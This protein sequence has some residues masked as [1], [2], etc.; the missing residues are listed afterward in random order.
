M[1]QIIRLF[2]LLI[3]VIFL[4][5]SWSVFSEPV[6]VVD[7]TGRLVSLKAPANR[8]VTLAPS[9]VEITYAAGAG[10]KVVGTVEYSDYPAAALKIPRVGGYSRIDLEAIID[11]KPDL[12][13]GWESGNS[14]TAIE[15]LRQL[16]IPVYLSQPNKITDIADDI[17]RIGILAGTG[18]VANKTAHDFRKRYKSLAK[19]YEKRPPVRLFYQISPNPLITIGGQQVI[20]DAIKVCGGVNVFEGLKPM[21]PRVNFESVL[22]ENPEVII[23]SGM[24]SVHPELLDAWKKWP[25]LQATRKNNFFFI[26]SDLINRGGPRIL[27]GTKIL[28]ADLQK[29]RDRR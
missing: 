14:P 20:T 10:D 7:G 12:V 22:E 9:A 11:S 17:E 29:V 25:N 26:Q 19:T 23:T 28:C 4:T 6:K 15:K 21:A 1:T 16:G 24:Y 8:I 2:K 27:E 3:P 18:S 13:F 5:V